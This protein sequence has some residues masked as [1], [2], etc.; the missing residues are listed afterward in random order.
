MEDIKGIREPRMIIFWDDYGERVICYT[1]LDNDMLKRLILQF[2]EDCENGIGRPL[3]EIVK[4][5][6]DNETLDDFG[7]FYEFANSEDS[8]LDDLRE[9][10]T[11]CIV[12]HSCW[13]FHV[14]T[15]KV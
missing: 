5:W 6:I 12:E 8:E 1:N 15:G 9:L 7:Y 11:E 14:V 2:D 3:S 10:D 13:S 4:E